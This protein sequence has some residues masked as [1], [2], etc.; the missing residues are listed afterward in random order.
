MDS[1]WGN[2]PVTL[3]D[4][5][6][7]TLNE[8]K[9]VNATPVQ[10]ACIPLFM[11]NKD[12]AAEAVTGSGKT[13]AFLIPILEKLNKHHRE[14]G[15][16]KKQEIFSVIVTPTRELAFQIKEVLDQ[17]LQKYENVT[18]ILF[19]GGE[20]LTSDINKFKSKGGEKMYPKCFFHIAV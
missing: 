7:T 10:E 11:G 17:F 16:L 15:K 14:S 2:L 20:N 13:L 19:I 3:C 18:S 6:L 4:S 9:F 12:V 8:L 1:T 5:T